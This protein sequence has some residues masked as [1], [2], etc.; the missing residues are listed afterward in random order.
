M[1]GWVGAPPT[2]VVGP[3]VN[4]RASIE[5]VFDNDS[6]DGLWIFTPILVAPCDK[7]DKEGKYVGLWGRMEGLRLKSSSAL[8]VY[9]LGGRISMRCG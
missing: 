7:D 4:S 5:E 6:V 1:C 9:V 8:P 2:V 3:S